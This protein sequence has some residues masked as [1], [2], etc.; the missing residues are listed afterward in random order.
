MLLDPALPHDGQALISRWSPWS[1]VFTALVASALIALVLVDLDHF[2]APDELTWLT[3]A[4]GVGR[5]L[6]CRARA[7]LQGDWD[8]FAKSFLYFGWLSSRSQEHSAMRA[9]LLV[10]VVAL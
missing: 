2:L 6:C 8:S 1:F 4:L 5:D 3:L 7:T 9:S 10:S